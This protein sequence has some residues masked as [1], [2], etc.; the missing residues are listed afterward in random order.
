[1]SAQVTSLLPL[2][3][4]AAPRRRPQ[5]GLTLI[6]LMFWAILV[7]VAALLVIRVAP[8]L[9]EF[10]TIQRAVNKIASQG[11]NTVPEIRAAFDKQVQIDYSISSIAGKDLAV[12]KEND[13][14]VIRFGYDKEVPLVEPVYLLIKFRG[15]SPH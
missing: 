12:S 1:V 15:A 11:F 7:A 5:R 6:G 3:P 13:R 14:I 4:A 10:F 9:N 2:P 8:T